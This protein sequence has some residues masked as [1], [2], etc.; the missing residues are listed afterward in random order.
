M[1]MY[2]G[3]LIVRQNL[4]TDLHADFLQNIPDF[5]ENVN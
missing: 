4:W 5:P 2:I 3:I 1:K